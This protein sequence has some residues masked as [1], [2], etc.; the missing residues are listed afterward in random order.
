M[1]FAAAKTIVPHSISAS[2]EIDPGER[3]GVSPLVAPNGH[4]APT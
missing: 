2:H 4:D 3:G 1:V